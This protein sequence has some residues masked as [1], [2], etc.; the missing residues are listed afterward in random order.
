MWS[1]QPLDGRGLLHWH[2]RDVATLIDIWETQREAAQ[3]A[4]LA[5]KRREV[6]G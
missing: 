3:E 6:M 5:E 2:P 1:G 4:R